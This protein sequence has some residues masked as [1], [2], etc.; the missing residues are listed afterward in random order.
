MIELVPL[1]SGGGSLWIIV[2]IILAFWVYKI[3]TG[4]SSSGRPRPQRNP[5]ENT[6]S[7]SPEMHGKQQSDPTSDPDSDESESIG[8]DLG[9]GVGR[10]KYT[11][12]RDL[13]DFDPEGRSREPASG[14]G[15]APA[16]EDVP[17][18]DELPDPDNLY[19]DQ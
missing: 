2:G 10:D 12:R 13:P 5:P 14:S 4:G 16:L 3:E 15:D 17:S 9:T 1:Q 18:M 19:E 6:G 8:D 7:S 11:E